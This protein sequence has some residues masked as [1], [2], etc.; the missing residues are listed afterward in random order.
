V[1]ALVFAIVPLR[2]LAAV[3]RGVVRL[4]RFIRP[5]DSAMVFIF[6]V[7]L[8]HQC[9]AIV[10]ALLNER[11]EPLFDRY[12]GA[13]CRVIGGFGCV[14]T[15]ATKVPRTAGFHRARKA[16]AGGNAE[17]TLCFEP[18]LTQKIQGRV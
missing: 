15:E 1:F 8:P 4:G 6:G 12:S 10:S 7:G 16:T 17:V 11:V 9:A 13:A 3:S 2:T 5:P 18:R 14:W